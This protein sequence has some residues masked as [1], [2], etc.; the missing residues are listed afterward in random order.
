MSFGVVDDAVP[1]PGWKPAE[2][3]GVGVVQRKS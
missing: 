3:I 1:D 2:Q